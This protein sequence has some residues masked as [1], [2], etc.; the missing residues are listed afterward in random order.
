ML[1]SWLVGTVLS[2]LGLLAIDLYGS[3]ILL[4]EV[5]GISVLLKMLLLLSLPLFAAQ[6][7]LWLLILLVIFS[8]F[9][10]HSTRG[11][12]HKNLLPAAW[13]VKLGIHQHRVE[14]R[15]PSK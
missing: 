4:F 13:Q 7:Q 5:R 14:S 1:Y 12:R 11:L 15:S 6:Y 2:G 10:S 8:S 3:C 9:V